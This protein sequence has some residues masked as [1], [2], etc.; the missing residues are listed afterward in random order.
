MNGSQR[1]L[2]ACAGQP[3]DRTPVWMMRQAGRYLARISRRARKKST[4]SRCARRPIWRLEVSLQPIERFG[5]DACIVF[6]DILIPVEAMGLLRSTFGDAGPTIKAPV[7]TCADVDRLRVPEPPC[8]PFVMRPLRIV[9]RALLGP[10]RARRFCRRSFTLATYLIEGGGSRNF[11]A[12]KRS[13]YASPR[14][15]TRCSRSWLR[16]S[17]HMPQR[18]SRLA[19]K[20]CKSSIR[21]PAS[22]RRTYSNCSHRLTSRRDRRGSDAPARPSI[23][24]VN[25]CAG[26]FDSLAQQAPMF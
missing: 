26:K 6:C 8:M 24:F 22:S 4:S 16:R 21:G 2:A 14:S 19:H 1:F 25:G 10:S 12:T 15:C 9:R 3:V 23:L 18:K 17:P 20:P 7:R 11:A 5:M 13:I